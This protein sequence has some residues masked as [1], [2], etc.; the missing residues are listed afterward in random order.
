MQSVQIL[1]VSDRCY[2]QETEIIFAGFAQTGDVAREGS[3]PVIIL[4]DTAMEEHVVPPSECTCTFYGLSS[5]GRASKNQKGLPSLFV[6]A[7]CS[8]VML[9]RS[10]AAAHVRRD[11]KER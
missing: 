8:D 10:C 7:Q 11:R 4:A 6:P 3:A 1:Q 5:H 2:L 9:F